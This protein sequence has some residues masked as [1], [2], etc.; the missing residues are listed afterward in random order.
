MMEWYFAQMNVLVQGAATVRGG[1]IDAPYARSR[2]TLPALREPLQN[3]SEGNLPLT[4][5]TVN[6]RGLNLNG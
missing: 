3:F 5:A 6:V 1:P 4:S 2:L